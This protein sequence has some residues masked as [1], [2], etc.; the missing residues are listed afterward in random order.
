[1]Q[2]VCIPDVEYVERA[3]NAAR[4]MREVGLDALVV[5]GNEA[6]YANTRYF[7][8]FWPLFERCGVAI[9]PDGDAA[10]MVGPESSIYAEDFGKI[11]NIFVMSEYRESADPDYPHLRLQTYRDV[12]AQLGIDPSPKR[13]GVASVLDTNV[14]QWRGLAEAFPDAEL[15]DA[16]RLMT[17][18]RS[19]KTENE[20]SCLREA[21]RITELATHAVV[22]ALRPGVTEL[23][24]VGVAQQAI[25]ANGAEYEGLPMYVFSEKST[26]HAISRS[27]YREINKGDIVQLNLS[28]KIDGYSP[29]IG[30][31]VSMGPISGE[32][33]EIVEFVREMHMWTE[34]KLAPGLVAADIAKA[35]EAEFN[36][37]GMGAA[38]LYGPCHG[39]GLIEVEAPWMETTSDYRLE[40]QMTFQIDTF[41]MGSAFGCRWEKPIVVRDKGIDLLSPQL[42]EIIEVDC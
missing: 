18:L 30:M 7:S 39:L 28:A 33:R 27:S 1:M 6:D 10:L 35:F 21:A 5:N 2:R 16:R 34:R 40:P 41:G 32:K 29:S 13:I 31:P 25:Y 22:E 17:Q 4:L 23:E 26:K 19:H 38:F 8:G 42:P 20:I 24:M 3:K 11:S 37:R 9:N 14:V 36:R 15:V 12:F